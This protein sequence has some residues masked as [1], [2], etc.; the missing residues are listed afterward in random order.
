MSLK[1]NMDP[2]IDELLPF[3]ALDALTPEE[4][5]RVES[6]LTEHPEARPQLQELQSGASAL[7]N[8][9]ALV[10]PPPHIK[11]TLMRRVEADARAHERSSRRDTSSMRA[12]RESARRGLRLED[13]FRVLS[14]GAAVAAILWAFV[15]NAQVARLQNEISSLNEKVAA[16]SQ[17]IDDLVRNLPQPDQSDV[18]TVS[19]MSTADENCA[20]GQL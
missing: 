20:L 13:I 8:S 12:T 17:S 14:L 18:I 19:L 10:V 5:E 16:Q 11:E 2:D 9:V 15:L 7:P 1:A 4:K 3:Y 6:Y